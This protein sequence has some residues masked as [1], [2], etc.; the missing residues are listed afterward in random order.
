M[1]ASKGNVDGDPASARHARLPTG[2]LFCRSV[3]LALT[4]ALTRLS[5][6]IMSFIMINYCLIMSI[7]KN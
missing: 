3:S 1:N 2:E 4:V 7:S 5:Y 6:E